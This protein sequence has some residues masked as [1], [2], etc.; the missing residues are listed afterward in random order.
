MDEFAKVTGCHCKAAIKHK[1]PYITTLAA[2][3]VYMGRH[4]ERLQRRKE[5]KGRALEVM[6]TWI[7]ISAIIIL[8][9]L[10]LLVRMRR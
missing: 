2:F 3:D 6:W 4:L 7:G 1:V 8:I 9:V 10:F 5:V